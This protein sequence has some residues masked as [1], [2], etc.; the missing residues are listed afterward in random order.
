[1]QGRWSDG[2]KVDDMELKLSDGIQ[3]TPTAVEQASAMYYASHFNGQ[4][5]YIETY[6]NRGHWMGAPG[7]NSDVYFYPVHEEAVVEKLELKWRVKD[8]GQGE[9]LLENMKYKHNYLL[10]KYR[11]YDR[12]ARAEFNSYPQGV[13]NM[14][15]KIGTHNNRF[16]LI[17][18]NEYL[19][20]C[21][22]SHSR[23]DY[24]YYSPGS[25]FRF[26]TPPKSD[27]FGVVATLDNSGRDVK[28]TFQYLEEV[29]IGKKN[30]QTVSETLTIEIGLEIKSAFSFGMSHSTTWTNTNEQSYSKKVSFTVSADV[31]PGK[32]VQV[33][34]LV[35]NYGPFTVH[36]KHFKI[37]DINSRGKIQNV[38][39]VSDIGEYNF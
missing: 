6:E 30:G 15:F 18:G 39:Y 32:I 38:A 34:Q 36:A 11:S 9:V 25:E 8:L 2:G 14:K 1:M 27:H 16:N 28:W 12:Y 33:Q 21:C 26:Y 24:K 29:G 19:V 17:R 4:I 7:S 3:L 22:D 13:S 37:V 31:P 10:A 20:R 35:G 23:M 5:I